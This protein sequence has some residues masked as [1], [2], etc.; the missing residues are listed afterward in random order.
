MP[1]YSYRP[2]DPSHY[3]QRQSLQPQRPRRGKARVLIALGLVLVLLVVGGIAVGRTVSFLGQTANLRTPFS[4][5]GRSVAP[6]AGSLPWKLNHGQQVNVL[7]M[8]YGGSENEAPWLT[9]TM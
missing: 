3:R 5:F 6:P 8:G 9:D 1:T 4:E 7:L 2:P